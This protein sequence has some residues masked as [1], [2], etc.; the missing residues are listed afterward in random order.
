MKIDNIMD[1]AN[2][3]SYN[4][5]VIIS[6]FLICLLVLIID[7]ISKGKLNNFLT[8]RRGSLLNPMT[9]IRLVTSGLC[10]KDWTHFRNNF[11]MIL[12]VGPLLEEKYGSIPMLEMIIITTIAS[13]LVHLFIY[14][15]GAIGASD[16]VY[17]MVVLCSI[18][19]ISQ[20]KIPVTLILIF[21]FYVADEIIKQIFKRN[22]NIAHD[23]H[24]VGA[25]CGFIFG[26]FIF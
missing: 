19:N 13:S 11:V 20:G 14:E 10:H 24:I 25:I 12:L 21:L 2:Y 4:S 18:V 8:T 3:F 5:V 16:N 26:Y 22:D 23:S 7:T 17:M 15:N 1:I 6:Y 9:Y